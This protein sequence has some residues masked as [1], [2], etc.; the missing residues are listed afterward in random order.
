V[1]PKFENSL[2]RFLSKEFLST[3]NATVT[4]DCLHKDCVVDGKT[5]SLKIWDTAGREQYDS[6]GI[7][8]ETPLL[9]FLTRTPIL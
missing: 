1:H 6:L 7:F 9:E 8:I 2:Y 5:V 4:A 3:Y